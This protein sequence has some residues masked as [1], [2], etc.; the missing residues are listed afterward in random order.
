[1]TTA[2]TIL[3]WLGSGFAF[4]A[5]FFVGIWM[6]HSRVSSWT[7]EESESIKLL[8]ERNEIDRELVEDVSRISESLNAIRDSME[9]K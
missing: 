5:G 3:T 7:K 9:K 6:M 2:L 1:M 4:A 8:R